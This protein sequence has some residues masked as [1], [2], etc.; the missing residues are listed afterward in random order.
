MAKRNES[1]LTINLDEINKNND[2]HLLELHLQGW[3]FR[4]IARQFGLHHST[5][6]RRVTRRAKH[7]AN[8]LFRA[9]KE[10]YIDSKTT[11]EQDKVLIKDWLRQNLHTLANSDGTFYSGRQENNLSVRDT[12]PIGDWKDDLIEETKSND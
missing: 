6:Y 12:S 11:S 5:V 2:D 8:N 4:R 1:T 7:N 10:D 9:L 3:S